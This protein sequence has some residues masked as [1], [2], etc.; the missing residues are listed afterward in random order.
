M[1]HYQG[2]SSITLDEEFTLPETPPGTLRLDLACGRNVKKGFI[3]VDNS[4][5]LQYSKIIH[6]DESPCTVSELKGETC[7]KWNLTKTPW[8]FMSESVYE[9]S[10]LHYVEH[11]SDLESFMKELHRVL[12]PL[13]T[14]T[15][16]GPYYT[17]TGAYQDYTH[18]RFLN[19]NTMRYFDQEWLKRQGIDKIYGGHGVD[20]EIIN[21]VFI[22]TN[23]WAPKSEEAKV[24]ALKHYWNVAD[25]IM[26][27]L[28]KRK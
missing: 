24:Y 22:F 10:C 3:G 4:D 25:D 15:I 14:A 6:E 1:K 26:Y 9:V 27:V 19:E 17:S 13:G 21:T 8:P 18:K 23:E 20:F 12:I 11:I 16:G 2:R 7:L 28:R 5:Y